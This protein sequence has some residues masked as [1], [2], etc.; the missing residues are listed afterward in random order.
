MSVSRRALLQSAVA[1]ALGHAHGFP[2]VHALTRGGGDIPP[3]GHAD[4][5][6]GLPVF[7]LGAAQRGDPDKFHLQGNRALQIQV[8]ADGYC[9]VYEESHGQRWLLYPGAGRHPQWSIHQPGENAPATPV[10]LALTFKPSGFVTHSRCNQVLVER[11]VLCPEGDRPWLLIRTR[12]SLAADTAPLSFDYAEHWRVAPRPLQTF[13]PPAKRDARARQIGVHTTIT[14]SAVLAWEIRDP[15]ADAFGP[16]QVVVLES[17]QSRA[18]YTA[19]SAPSPLLTANQRVRL[20]AG[21]PVTIWHRYGYADEPLQDPAAFYRDDQARLRERLPRARARQLPAAQ[22]EIPWHSAA[23]IGGANRD[24]VLGGHTLN[25]GSAYAFK[26]GGNAAARD[27]LQHALPLVYI[28]PDLALSVLRNT[29]AWGSPDGDLPYA[30]TG[31]KQPLTQLLRPSDQN[32][33]ALWLA[34][35]YGLVTGDL[36]AFEQIQHYHPIHRAKPVTL[37]THLLRQYQFFSQQVGRGARGHVRMLNADWNDR[38]IEASGAAAEAMIARGSSVLNSA[39]AAWVLPVFA[40]LMRKLGEHASADAIVREGEALRQLVAQAWNGRWFDRA[41]GPDGQ[42]V[43]R[44]R[45]WLEVQ[46]WALLC[47]AAEPAQAHAL[48]DYIDNHH[49]AGSSFGARLIWPPDSKDPHV[50]EGVRGGIWYAVN[51]TLIWAATHYRPAL[52]VDEWRR[53]SLQQHRTVQPDVWEGTLS[54]PDAWNAPESARPGRT[55]HYP[56]LSMQS[57]PVGNMHSHSATVLAYLRLL[58]IAPQRDGAVRGPSA[59][60]GSFRSAY[61]STA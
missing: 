32:L 44:D 55:W 39:M 53:M 45:C 42:P 41:Y 51:M 31:N 36:A 12:F 50:G 27:S 34:A 24:A 16:E 21:E 30:L 8:A 26:A 33:W 1:A 58:G 46:P 47:G 9:G 10:H 40:A 18:G 37:K 56:F 59:I 28:A 61:F 17:V 3:G 57:F 19:S 15:T 14:E 4:W 43:G 13:E 25:Q 38:A 7:H 54:G 48:L 11:E 5:W 49:R 22:W 52:A 6:E 60:K 23:L 29:C 20:S 2:A 35:E